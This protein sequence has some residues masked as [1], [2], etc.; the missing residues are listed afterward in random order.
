MAWL[1]SLGVFALLLI[2]GAWV[3]NAYVVV[4][5]KGRTFQAAE[6]APAVDA[7]I[8]PGASVYR[9]GRLSPVLRQRMEG[10]LRYLALH[11]GVKLILSGHAIPHGYSETTAMVEFARANAVPEK[12][13]MVDDRG[14][15][16]YVTLL[17]FRRASPLRRILIVSQDYHLPRALY[18]AQAMG[19]ESAGLVVSE[20][21]AQSGNMPFREYF[22][23]LKDFLL[24]RVSG[25]F[26][27]N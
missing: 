15:S 1:K 24:L 16:T 8:V 23:R 19:F 6:D 10:A 9:S 14:R 26:N 3:I 18:I 25:W 4:K 2:V 27:A 21:A 7:V 20:D 22:T 11:K 17:N 13:I 12:D 5:G